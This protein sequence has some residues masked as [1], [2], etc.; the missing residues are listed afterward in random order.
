MRSA[1]LILCMFALPQWCSGQGRLIS[2]TEMNVRETDYFKNIAGDL[3]LNEQYRYI[4]SLDFYHVSYLSDGLHINGFVVAPSQVNTLLP[5]VI[6]NRGGNRNFASIGIETLLEWIAPIARAGYIV[7]ASQYRGGGGSDGNDEF[8]GSDVNDVL[9]LLPLISEWPEADTQRIGMY[10]W[11]RGGMMTYIALSKT[12]R[13]K[14]AV[15]GGAPTDLEAELTLRPKMD[16]LY[17]SLIPGYTSD[18][19]TALCKRSAIY[20]PERLCPSTPVLILHGKKDVRA[21]YKQA[22]AM[23]DTLHALRR[24]VQLKLFENGDHIISSDRRLK[25]E[26]VINWFRQYL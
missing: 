1:V 2:K 10:G 4:D 24:P 22:R 12:K 6:F 5:V 16:E 18:K 20:W 26:M 25:D 14:A 7:V 11:S 21:D 9:N 3:Q 15:I 13:I 8:G 23:F 17:A 19:T